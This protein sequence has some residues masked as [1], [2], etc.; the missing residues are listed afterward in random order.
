MNTKFLKVS[1]GLTI[2]ALMISACGLVPAMGSG[3][4]ITQS[5]NVSGFTRV[6]I[7]GGGDAEIIQDGSEA[8]TIETDDNV[9]QYITSEVRGDTLYLGMDFN[10]LRSVIPTRLHFTIHV[11]N[12]NGIATSGSWEVTSASIQTDSLEISISGS[13][14]INIAALTADR[15]STSVSGSGEVTLAGMASKQSITVS[16]SG[17][18][19]AGDLQTQDSQIHIS[20][21]GNATLWATQTLGVHISGSG[22]VSYYGAPQVEFSQSGSGS[23]QSLG[24]K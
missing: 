2:L 22:H 21:S 16:G 1:I 8:L 10:G 11:K 3:R 19:F 20:G 24:T 23:I 15:V 7:G 17:K 6:E 5:R 9:M 18:Y 4:L 13:G 14:K 12:L